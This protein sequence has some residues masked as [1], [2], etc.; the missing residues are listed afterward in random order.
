LSG[1]R[2]LLLLGVCAALL[3]ASPAAARELY[4]KSLEVWATL[5]RVGV[6]HVVERQHMVFTGDWNGGERQFVGRNVEV[7]DDKLALVASDDLNPQRSRVL[8]RQALL[9]QRRLADIQRL[10]REY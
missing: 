8:L 3:A 6:L 5:D 10:F 2:A 4:W 1:L 9:K 7:G